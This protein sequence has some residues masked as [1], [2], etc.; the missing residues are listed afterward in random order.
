MKK[1]DLGGNESAVA[2]MRDGQLK[3][4]LPSAGI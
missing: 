2:Q 1:D 4:G 3:T